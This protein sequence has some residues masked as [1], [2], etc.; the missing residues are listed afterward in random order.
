MTFEDLCDRLI[1]IDEVSLLELL[2]INSEELVDKFQ[3]KIEDKR[4]YLE[5]ELEELYEKIE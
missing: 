5:E 4:D 2:E 3:D 1:H